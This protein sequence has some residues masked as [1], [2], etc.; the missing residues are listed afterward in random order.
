MLLRTLLVDDE[1]PVHEAM[2]LMVDWNQLG[3]QVPDS[4]MDGL[5]ALRMMEE[6][7]YDVVITDVC[8]P[9]ME[10]LEFMH[11]LRRLKS[12]VQILVITGFDRFSYAQEAIRCGARDCFLKPLDR[13]ELE[14]RLRSLA[15]ELGRTEPD[16][17]AAEEPEALCSRDELYQK[18]LHTLDENFRQNIT[19]Q[20]LAEMFYVSP[21][22]LG[23]Y[24]RRMNGVPIN[25]YV[26]RKRIE[27]VKSRVA[28]KSVF[29]Q[30]VIAEAGYQN[31]G[32]FYRKFQE[33]EGVS[34][35]QWRR[36]LAAPPER[37]KAQKP[38][39]GDRS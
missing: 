38:D 14:E 28:R 9:N 11:A 33:I 23:Q 8:M 29:V 2:K 20:G 30:E 35:A 15:E 16:A 18:V 39:G 26:N 5:Q 21:A 1:W 4:A 25:E 27:W 17:E 22:Y 10:G 36:Q 24:F 6:K 19:V 7:L 31:S 34:F 3:Y 13:H 12:R 32:Y 37:K